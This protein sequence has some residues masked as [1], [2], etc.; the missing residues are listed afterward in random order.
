M[1][2]SDIGIS[3]PHDWQIAH[4]LHLLREQEVFLTSKTGSGKSALT[5]ATVIA[6]KLTWKAHIAIVIYPTESLII[7]QVSISAMCWQIGANRN[8]Y[9]RRRH[10]RGEYNS[11]GLVQTFLYQHKP[12][13]D[14]TYG[15]K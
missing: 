14:E 9:R 5:L 4:S 11:L 3:S 8:G 10:V 15:K 1:E 7:D 12:W 6:Q 2:F 13:R